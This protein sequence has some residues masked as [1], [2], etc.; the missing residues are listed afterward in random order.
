MIVNK[1]ISQ[2]L[3]S[4]L[5]SDRL[6]TA[7]QYM[8]DWKV[9][10]LPVVAN[11]LLLGLLEE[12]AMIGY[13]GR[14]AKV[15]DFQLSP[16]HVLP[17]QH[18]FEVIELIST[19]QLS[20]IPVADEDRHYLGEISLASVVD[21]MADLQSVRQEGS[22]LVLEMNDVDYSLSE[23]SRLIEG[24]DAKVLSSSVTSFDDSRKVEVSLKINQTRIRGIVQTLQ[25]FDYTIK[26]Y[27]D[28]PNYEDDLK[29]R[30]DELMRYLNI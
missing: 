10:H 23:I 22:I 26:A 6:D 18:I 11:G 16:I 24:N 25:R 27:Y 20:T 2:E 14:E 7:L 30:Y 21:Y 13:E 8:Q 5:P 28:A 4:L 9:S 19:Y 12:S 3:P 1:I 29:K 15:S 17:K